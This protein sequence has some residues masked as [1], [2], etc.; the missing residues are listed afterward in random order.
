MALS[1]FHVVI[2]KWVIKFSSI[3]FNLD[4]SYSL[5]ADETVIL[6]KQRKYYVWFLVDWKSKKIVAWHFS[7]YRDLSNALKLFNKIKSHP[8]LITTDGLPL[9]PYAVEEL[10][11]KRTF[12]NV[13]I[14][15][16]TTPLNRDIHFSKTLLEQSADSKSFLTSSYTQTVSSSRMI[17]TKTVEVIK[18]LSSAL[19]PF[20]IYG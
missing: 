17:F 2:Y 20:I 1:I 19:F 5:S 14:L 3:L 11:S 16:I 13:Y 12:I 4:S 7:K 18:T 6:F 8:S 10:F 15:V 9:Y